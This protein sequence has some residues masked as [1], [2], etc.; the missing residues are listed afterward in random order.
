MPHPPRRSH[1]RSLISFSIFCLFS[2]AALLATSVTCAADEDDDEDA[3]LPGLPAHYEAQVNGR[4]VSFR[5]YDA[6]PTFRLANGESP[7]PRLPAQDWRVTWKGVLAVKSPGKYQ[8]AVRAPG[9]VGIRVDGQEVVALRTFE[10]PLAEAEGK[11]VELKFGPRRLEIEFNPHGPAQLRIFWQSED[12]P[13][14]PLPARAVGHLSQPGNE[15][16][17]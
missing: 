2:L 17:H 5:R 10:E 6:L 8:L 7:D 16:D 3:V 9:P 4:A 1:F 15:V 14:E 11:P 12:F 13:R